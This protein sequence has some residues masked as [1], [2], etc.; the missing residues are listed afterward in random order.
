MTA[1]QGRNEVRWGP[2]QEASLA[3]PCSNLRCLGSKCIV[4]KK[5]LVTLLGLFGASRSDSAF[6]PL[7]PRRYAPRLPDHQRWD[8]IRIAGDDCGRILRFSFGPGSGVKIWEN[9][10]PESL[11]HFGSSRSLLGQ[12]PFSGKSMTVAAESEQESDFRI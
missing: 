2:G 12:W 5:V 8:R 7:A 6:C 1:Q 4:L 11:F 3:P 9:P 10:D